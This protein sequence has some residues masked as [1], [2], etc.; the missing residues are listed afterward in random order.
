MAVT[1]KLNAA[2]LMWI[3][4][5]ILANHIEGDCVQFKEIDGR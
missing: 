4:A 5:N 2:V 1:F 3:L